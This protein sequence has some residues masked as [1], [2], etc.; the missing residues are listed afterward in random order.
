MQVERKIC[1]PKGR[2]LRI[3]QV[4]DA[5][6]MH[7]VRYALPQML[8]CA[9][10]AVQPDLVVFTGDNIHGN[11]LDEDFIGRKTDDPSVILLHMQQ[12][13]YHIL[14]PVERRGIPFCMIFGNHDDLVLF[15]KQEQA[16]L[17]KDYPHFFGLND[18]EPQ[19]DCDTYNVPIYTSDGE[20]VAFNLWMLDSA[21]K[22][23][24]TG[25][26]FEYVKPEAVEWYKR[27]SSRLKAENGGEPVPSLMFQHVPV[28]QVR[29]LFI[30]CAEDDPD[31]VKWRGP[32]KL[33]YKL[34][35]ARA[36]GYA[37]EYPDVCEADFGQL[38]A[39]RE[40]GD[41]CAL[42]FGHDH[43]NNF[44]CD[45]DGVQIVQTP[46]ASFRSYGTERA[47][48]VRVFEIDE[49]DPWN[50]ETYTL[51]YYDLVGNTPANRVAFFMSADEYDRKRVIVL[52]AAAAAALTAGAAGIVRRIC[53]RKKNK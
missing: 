16:D 27:E 38:D 49:N 37:D 1:F 3:L 46:G 18:A 42:V 7:F 50:V 32:D 41:V 23:D 31:A 17:F 2:K 11:H 47:R 34:D 52:G 53:K 19:L 30:P 6:D 22:D 13:L 33:P 35:P 10:D 29:D 26:G 39:I 40:Q 48:G 44:T 25:K 14:E 8:D 45:L 9:Y 28:P 15:S 21:G 4:S 36:D 12:A 5:Q 51:N 43:A 24:G 20:K